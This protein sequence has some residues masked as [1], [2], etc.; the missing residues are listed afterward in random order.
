MGGVLVS[1]RFF[2]KLMIFSLLISLSSCQSAALSAAGMNVSYTP[3]AEYPAAGLVDSGS[4]IQRTHTPQPAH[5]DAPAIGKTAAP[6]SAAP[7]STTDAPSTPQPTFDPQTWSSLPIIPDFSPRALEILKDGLAKGQNP[8]AFSKIGD[9]E[10]QASWF[11]GDFDLRPKVY[12]LGTYE[13]DLQPV[14]DHF[15]G[16]FKRVSLAARP[17]FS[18]A[19][20]MAPIWADKTICEKNETPLACEYR[21]QK[22][23]VAFILLGSNDATNPKTFEGH[24]RKVIEFSI[25]KGVLPILGTKAD[26]TEGDHYINSK[27]AQLAD[28]YQIP[29]WNYWAAVQNLPGH[30][31]QED[32]VH[33]TFGTAHFDDPQMMKK[34]W[35][36][37]NLNALQVLERVMKAVETIQTSR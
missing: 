25:S 28:E 34:A 21:V 13:S 3:T 24:M 6:S 18:S 12:S 4:S 22:P 33:L 23:I 31:L 36:V 29:L 15:P 35:P 16:S 1:L 5:P 11:L 32:G 9:C 20:L 14:I 19:S 27:I 7:G 8:N 10:S 37:R 2:K 17:G 30:G 26:N